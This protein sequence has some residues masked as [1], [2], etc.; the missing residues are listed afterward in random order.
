MHTL[1]NQSDHICARKKLT[2][3]VIMSLIWNI[4]LPET[5]S[6]RYIVMLHSTLLLPPA[7]VVRREG[8]VL[9]RVCPSIHDSV[10][11][12]GGGGQSSVQLGGGVR[13][14]GVGGEVRSSRRGGGQVQPVGGGVRSSRGGEVSQDRTTEW[15]VTT[16]R[17][18]CLLRS[19]R[20]TFLFHGCF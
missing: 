12:Q 11:P 8:H 2:L 13:S 14:S 19:R 10:C 9:T 15:V 17:A 6:R 1:L 4:S 20:R 7:Y 16:R 5:F 18:V 3:S